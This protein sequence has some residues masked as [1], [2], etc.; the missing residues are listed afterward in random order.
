MK[1][2][3][4]SLIYLISFAFSEMLYVI[5]DN[6]EVFDSNGK[7]EIGIAFRGMGGEKIKELGDKT[8]LRFQGFIKKNDPLTLYATKDMSMPLIA[9]HQDNNSSTIE[10]AI[11]KQKLSQDLN[12]IWSE[13]KKIYYNKCSI[14]HMAI[15]PK[16]YS[17]LEWKSIFNTM[18]EFTVFDDLESRQVLDYLK[19]NASDGYLSNPK[20]DTK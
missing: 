13:T 19:F 18:K 10:V 2:F 11:S 14:C 16:D 12:N 4:I 6:T 17:V 3:L 5:D 15:S 20:K 8:I 7:N 9:F 1:K